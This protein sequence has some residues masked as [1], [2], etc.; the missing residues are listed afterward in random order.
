M[1][2]TFSQ[3]RWREGYTIAEVDAFL[4]QVEPRLPTRGRTD[5]V[6]A[7][8]ITAVRFSPVRINRGYDMF[9]VD[10]YLD[11]LTARATGRPP[12]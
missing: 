11:A 8:E 5:E 2:P 1:R 9:E 10:Q 4:D 6:L 12:G 3:T 7:A